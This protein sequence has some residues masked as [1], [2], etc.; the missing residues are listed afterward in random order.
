MKISESGICGARPRALPFKKIDE[1]LAV[2]SYAGFCAGGEC[3]GT[4][5]LHDARKGVNLDGEDFAA[6]C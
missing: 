1:T 2:H 4:D 6:T 3:C 5:I